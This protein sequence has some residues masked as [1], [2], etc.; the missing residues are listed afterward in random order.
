MF[1]FQIEDE[2][3]NDIFYSQNVCIYDSPLYLIGDYSYFLIEDSKYLILFEIVLI[4][5]SY[6]NMELK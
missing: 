5:L 4:E 1:C 2:D 3:R 6:G